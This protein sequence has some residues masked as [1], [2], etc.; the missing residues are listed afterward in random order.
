MTTYGLQELISESFTFPVEPDEGSVSV[1]VNYEWGDLVDEPTATDE[2]DDEYSIELSPD[3]MV[4]AGV[5]SIRWSCEVSGTPKH[6]NTSFYVEEKYISEND[7][8]NIYEDMNTSE[9]NNDIFNR[10]ERIA[11]K[12]IDTFCGQ[13]FQ[14]VGN[15]VV[16]KDGN[17][18][19][20]L[21][22]GRRLVHLDSVEMS[23]DNRTEDYTDFCDIDWGSRYSIQSSEKFPQGSRVT[24]SGDWGW[25][26][27]PSNIR[28]ATSLLILDILEQNRREHHSY[29]ILRLDQDTNRIAFDSSMFSESTGNIDVDVLIMDYIYWIPDWI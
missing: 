13:S 28:E 11:R 17:D 22:I 6:F 16:N 20:K 29:G 5:Y 23:I 18:R 12:I 8:M 25:I 1:K 24:V 3:L 4:A 14:F 26:D 10:A 9:Y 7:F 2:G 27:P 15:K 19:Q 21:Y